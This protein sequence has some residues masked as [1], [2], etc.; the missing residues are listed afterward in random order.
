MS[1]FKLT[2]CNISKFFV[3][4][5]K[6]PI[7][8][9]LFLLVY[10]VYAID[11]SKDT[12]WINL[13][14]LTNGKQVVEDKNFYLSHKNIS[15]KSE[16]HLL[17]NEIENN[18]DIIKCRFPA[19]VYWLSKKLNR[20][21]V[22]FSSCKGLNEFLTKAPLDNINIVFSS[23]NV[24]NPSSMM[25]HTYLEILGNKKR[26]ALT[27]YTNMDGLN[28]P[29][30]IFE[31]LITGKKGFYALAPANQLE[32][33]YLIKEGRNI[34]KYR[35]NLNKEQKKILHLHLY[36][37]RKIELDYF[38]HTFNCAT[39]MNYI[40][41]TVHPSINNFKATW[42]TPLDLI[43]ATHQSKLIDDTKVILADK[44]FI[45]AI[46]ENFNLT[47]ENTKAIKERGI[48]SSP[49][50]AS[51]ELAKAYNRYLYIQGEKSFSQYNGQKEK[52]EKETQEKFPD[53]YLDFSDYKNPAK[54]PSNSQI[55]LSHSEFKGS[56][57]GRSIL[58]FLPA[59]HL[60]TDDSRM[61][62]N[63]SE[64]RVGN[65][66]VSYE[67]EKL[68]LNKFLL[69]KADIF[70]INDS[71]TGGL[72]GGFQIGY[73]D[74]I[75]RNLKYE[76]DFKVGVNFGK[77]YRIHRDIDIYSIV[78]NSLTTSEDYFTT[79]VKAG[80]ILRSYESLKFHINYSYI[81]YVPNEFEYLEEL[82]FNTSYRINR[83][84]GSAFNFKTRETSRLSTNQ[85]SFLLNIYL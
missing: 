45:K 37:L 53:N 33:D 7:I 13:L 49:D 10:N 68:R 36:E 14:Y 73:S 21:P 8:G 4:L 59:S 29:K 81:F 78:K 55:Y 48:P 2:V 18:L 66:E 20:T 27:F 83:N 15:P 60:L 39:L 3:K 51:L 32:K 79:G 82:N 35:L 1:Q 11:L 52:I 43:R 31:S 84:L 56:K 9:A 26:H 16:L 47:T 65:I 76:N 75:N 22:D 58:G 57:K 46:Y 25:G 44:W 69:I 63:E 5:K 50:L 54:N 42:M 61:Y 30:V 77:T 24:S 19:R 70:Q 72:S 12:Q 34:W 38:F 17:K 28:L 40:I 67:N 62:I 41:A 80:L 6:G 23:E 71:L 85:I 74:H 64:L